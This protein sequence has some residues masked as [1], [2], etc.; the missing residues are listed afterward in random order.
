MKMRKEDEDEDE[1]E[2]EKDYNLVITKSPLSPPSQIQVKI[3]KRLKN[4]EDGPDFDDSWTKRIV[5]S[6]SMF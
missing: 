1:D 2:D 5:S 6:R 4:R 3:F